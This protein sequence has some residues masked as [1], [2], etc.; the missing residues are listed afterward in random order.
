MLRKYFDRHY[1]DQ[2]ARQIILR[3]NGQSQSLEIVLNKEIRI[4]N[5]E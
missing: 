4:Y 2:A 5:M 1:I 3:S